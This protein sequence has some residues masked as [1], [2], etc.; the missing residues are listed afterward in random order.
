MLHK[1]IQTTL[2]LSSR[3]TI[4]LVVV[5]CVHVHEER[6]KKQHIMRICGFDKEK[7][8]LTNYFNWPVSTGA[9]KFYSN[10]E[11]IECRRSS[12]VVVLCS[13]KFVS[14][15]KSHVVEYISNR[16]LV[17]ICSVV[18]HMKIVQVILPCSLNK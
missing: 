8:F 4:S 10:C 2:H 17:E 6:T 7:G 9:S 11:N 12:F 16:F 15:I 5:F 14:I 1:R 13:V 3:H 18:F